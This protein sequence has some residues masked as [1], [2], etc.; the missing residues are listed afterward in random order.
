MTPMHR[1]LKQAGVNEAHEQATIGRGATWPVNGIF[2][3]IT[4]G[5]RID[6]VYLS[7]SLRAI[8]CETGV[9]EGSDHRPVVVDVVLPE[10]QNTP[11]AKG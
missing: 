8:R 6:H 4:P 3:Y 9:G 7:P 5:I 2:R 1:E 10:L 11:Q